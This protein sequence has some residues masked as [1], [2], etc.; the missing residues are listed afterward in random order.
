MREK[1]PSSQKTYLSRS[2]RKQRGL[3]SVTVT[4]VGMR[5]EDFLRFV[6]RSVLGS[7]GYLNAGWRVIVIGFHFTC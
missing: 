2:V 4:G 5:G 6:S 7:V 3:V 1:K